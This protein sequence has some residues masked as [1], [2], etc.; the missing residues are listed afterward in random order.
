VCAVVNHAEL[1][2]N[3]EIVALGLAN[4]AGAMFG[5]CV[6]I[7]TGSLRLLLKHAF[8]AAGQCLMQLS[9]LV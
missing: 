2:Y 7:G 1:A 5:R 8:A 6:T 9:L 4:F 3:Q